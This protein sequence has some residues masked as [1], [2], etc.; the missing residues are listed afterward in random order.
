MI[1]AILIL[2][3]LTAS[4]ANGQ[5]AS[6][7]GQPNDALSEGI[8]LMQEKKWD[9]SIRFFEQ[10]VKRFPERWE[11]HFY[12][13]VSYLE[14]GQHSKA[15]SEL[16]RAIRID[17]KR[18]EAHLQIARLFEETRRL[19]EAFDA[20]DKV[21]QVDPLG[22]WVA[23][24]LL[25]KRLIEGIL[26]ARAGDLQ[27]ALRLFEEAVEMAPDNP[28]PHFNVGLVHLRRREDPLA[29]AAFLKVIAL[30]PRHQDAY[31]NLG[32]LY[33]RHGRVEEAMAAYA[34]GFE[35]NPG[36]PGGRNARVK[37]FL[38]QGIL[39]ARQGAFD[40]AL[41][42]FAQTLQ[43]S[44]ESAP[45]YF[46]IGLIHLRLGNFS[47]AEEGLGRTLRIDPAHQGAALNLGILYERQ[48]KLEEALS[49]Y[50]R[51]RDLNSRTQDGVSAA[52]SVH[53]V[54]GRRSARA[55]RLDE[56]LAEFQRTT[57]VQPQNAANFFN[58]GLIYFQK[59][60]LPSA[61]KAFR[62]VIKLNP[63]E[64]DAYMALADIQESTGREKEAIETYERFLAVGSGPSILRAEVRLHLLKGV[65]FGREGKF[66]QARREFEEMVRIDPKERRGYFNLGLA[67]LKRKKPDAA[68][69][70]FKKLLELDPTD[71][72]IRYRLASLYEELGRPN[73]ALDFYQAILEDEGTPP[74]LLDEVRDRVAVLFSTLS[75]GYQV[76]YDSNINLSKE[77]LSDFKSDLFAQYQRLFDFGK[78]WRGGLRLS[79][80]FSVFQRSQVSFFNVQAGLFGEKRGYQRGMT[81][82]Y[83]FRVGLFE[84]SLSD[85]SHEL[86]FDGYAP[87]GGSTFTGSARLR[88]TESFVNPAFDG[89]QP[90]LSAGLSFD[91]AG[92][93]ITLGS[94]LFGNMNS[95]RVGEDYAYA[96]LSP[97]VSYDTL[98]T[99]GI[100]L[101]LSY[102]YT[103][104]RYLHADSIFGKRRVNQSHSA[105][106]GFT[107]AL[108]KG[109]QLFL[110]GSWL[111]NRSNL[112]GV[113]PKTEEALA[114]EQ[115][116]S[117]GDYDKWFGIIGLRLIF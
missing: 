111:E 25:K 110:K 52:V 26:Q 101:N 93:R 29:E 65:L 96:A 38:L 21:I 84:G 13:G 104:A 5:E 66:D 14:S 24:S 114:V 30:N 10:A 50:E 36:N 82:G 91:R 47:E 42:V 67:H 90:S 45:A 46:N 85:R 41:K 51:A 64:G 73:E 12:L 100:V 8:H 33:E 79:P 102:G 27:T 76:T 48:G 22:E 1:C 106:G 94:A 57:E 31:L 116:S 4:P 23:V 39:L 16:N 53:T 63:A 37:V 108:E 89:V 70:A 69:E 60:D 20:Y 81:A 17:P 71:R 115:I 105:G 107:V 72:S 3:F 112:E 83:N 49:A 62:Q 19:Q 95:R 18:V 55:G 58:V 2:I 9:E 35:I 44:P 113:S 61:E 78:G 54:R 117:L 80:N 88:H 103:Y 97:S 43:L 77:E 68:L 32:D 92:G 11:S 74:A 98:L 7:S 56:A 28:D 75:V 6:R 87:A 15:E 99:Q 34:K 109:L 86:T 40:S 59:N